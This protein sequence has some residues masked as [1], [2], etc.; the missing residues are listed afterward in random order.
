VSDAFRGIDFNDKAKRCRP[1]AESSVEF[2]IRAQDALPARSSLLLSCATPDVNELCIE[3][4]GLAGDGAVVY[5]A[6][7]T[8]EL[9]VG[10]ESI[11]DLGPVLVRK[12]VLASA[13]EQRTGRLFTYTGPVF[14]Q[15][16]LVA[17]LATLVGAEKQVGTVA[18]FADVA[19]AYRQ[20]VTGERV[21]VGSVVG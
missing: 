9:L 2:R 5:P 7:L 3:V 16:A 21:T 17:R 6:V 12:T 8:W 20:S 19:V 15:F 1:L 4:K 10:G 13:G 18:A 11:L 14:R